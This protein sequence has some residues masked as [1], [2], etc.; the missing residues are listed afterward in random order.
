MT[1]SGHSHGQARRSDLNAKRMM[2]HQ[3]LADY[4]GMELGGSGWLRVMEFNMN[5][6]VVTVTTYSPYLDMWDNS[7]KKIK[8]LNLEE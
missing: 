2:V 4:Q 3:L 7:N 5:K 1:V 8:P 6:N